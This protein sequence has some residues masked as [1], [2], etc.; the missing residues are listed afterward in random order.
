MHGGIHSIPE[1]RSFHR[2]PAPQAHH[3][4]VGPLRSRLPE[5]LAT[6]YTSCA[7]GNRSLQDPP[8]PGQRSAPPAVQHRRPGG[9]REASGGGGGFRGPPAPGLRL[10]VH[11]RSPAG[12]PSRSPRGPAPRPAILLHSC[13]RPGLP[14]P[15]SPARPPSPSVRIGWRPGRRH[16][17]TARGACGS[18]AALQA[19]PWRTARPIGARGV[20]RGGG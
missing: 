9:E 1:L 12:A 8:K 13:G 6:T 10:Q 4:S 19:R 15:P 3:S 2:L 5:P 17:P 18:P 7:P 14:P 11:T 20:G 16:F